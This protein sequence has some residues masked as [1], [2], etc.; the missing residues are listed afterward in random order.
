MERV[1]RVSLS[2]RG[3]C[4]VRLERARCSA[5]RKRKTCGFIRGGW[6]SRLQSAS[7]RAAKLA[8]KAPQRHSHVAL[9][10]RYRSSRFATGSAARDARCAASK[11]LRHARSCSGHADA[12]LVA[13]VGARIRSRTSRRSRHVA[14]WPLA[15]ASMSPAVSGRF[16]GVCA[17]VSGAIGTPSTK[18]IA[19]GSSTWRSAAV[20][21]PPYGIF[22]PLRSRH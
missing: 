16:P 5:W 19:A 22:Q 20:A 8:A 4:R 6:P 1:E 3:G 11:S 17:R 15:Y 10:R 18:A 21:D 12:A 9:P 14:A 13:K 7:V 2:L